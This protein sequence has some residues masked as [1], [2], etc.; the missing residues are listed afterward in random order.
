[1]LGERLAAAR[2]SRGLTQW[3]LAV[4][5]GDRYSQSGISS[6]E[7]GLSSMHL[8]GVMVAAQ[9]LRVSV[10]WLV[11][12][13]DDPTPPDER[14]PTAPAV[15]EPV[16]SDLNLEQ[17]RPFTVPGDSMSPTVPGGSTILVDCRRNRLRENRIFLYRTSGTLHVRRAALWGRVWWWVSDNPGFKRVR[18]DERDEIVGEVRWVGYQMAS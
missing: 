11:G 4:A 10:D 12:L 5:L 7:R 16:S 14:A 13:T 6:V 8:D 9:E 2:K 1:M 3:D 18:F 15:G 17:L